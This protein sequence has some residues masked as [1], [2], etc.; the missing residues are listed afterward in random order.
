MR[1]QGFLMTYFYDLSKAGLGRAWRLVFL[2]NLFLGN[3]SDGNWFC[4]A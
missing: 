2:N 3:D 1:L 4:I